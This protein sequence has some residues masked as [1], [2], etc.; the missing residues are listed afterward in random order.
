MQV[1]QNAK[2]EAET[3]Q[4]GDFLAYPRKWHQSQSITAEDGEKNE[5]K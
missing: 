5:Q 2:D 1:N 4:E 3:G